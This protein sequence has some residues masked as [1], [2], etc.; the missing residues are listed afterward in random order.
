MSMASP[1]RWNVPTITY[2]FD[3]S[4]LDYFGEDGVR[5]V[6]EA[7]GILND[8]PPMSEI[9]VNAYPTA[10]TSYDAEA[11]GLWMRDLKSY[12]L[13]ILLNQLGLMEP[14]RSTH[15]LRARQVSATETN[16]SLGLFNFDPVTWIP[17]TNVNDVEYTYEIAEHAHG[18]DAWELQIDPRDGA[19]TADA[20]RVLDFGFFYTGLTRDDVGGLRFLLRTNNVAV[21][22][23]PGLVSLATN[24]SSSG[25]AAPFWWPGQTNPIT[26]LVETAPRPGVDKLTFVRMRRDTNLQQFVALTNVFVDTYY[27]NSRPRQQTVQR[28]IDRP[29]ILFRARDL[30]AEFYYVPYGLTNFGY[31]MVPRLVAQ[32]D[33][34]RWINMMISMVRRRWVALA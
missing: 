26:N 14:T 13:S 21:E 25:A 34:S 16:Y 23:I 24:Q 33:T 30:G 19:S 17:A 28:I 29:D 11:G 9:D 27:T 15:T 7:F 18:T 1:Y 8:F 10:S 5:A 2:G 12:T 22:K 6:E 31:Y 32:S 3:Q 20:D 4:F